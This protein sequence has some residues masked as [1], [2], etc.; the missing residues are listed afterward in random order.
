MSIAVYGDVIIDEYIYGTATRLSPE[1][2][3]PVVDYISSEVKMGG[4]GNVYK[5]ILSLTPRVTMNTHA[6][7]LPVK[8]RIFADGHYVTRVDVTPKKI[9]W[10]HTIT[11]A[12]VIVFSDYNKGSYNAL[13]KCDDDIIQRFLDAKTIVDPKIHLSKYSECWCLKPNKKEF[14]AYVKCSVNL[15]NLKSLMVSAYNELNI[16]HLIV[17]L[18]SDGVAHYS[19]E[20]GYTHFPA[21]KVDVS[22]VTGAG[23][24]FT[25]VLAYAIDE[26]KTMLQAIAIANK[27]AGIAVKHHGTYVITPE[28]LGS[29]KE[30]VVFTNGCFD[31]LHPGHIHILREAKKLGTHL[32]VAINSDESVKRLKGPTRPVNSISHRVDM[33]KSLEI[34]DEVI[35]FNEDTPEELIK[36]IAPDIIVK[37]GDYNPQDVVGFDVAKVVIIP[38]LG[39][40]STTNII[41]GMNNGTA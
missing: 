6:E 5:N 32:I 9:E 20:T 34:A 23:D 31:I 38:T 7:D 4:A 10:V 13:Y 2:P 21:D 37:G 14:E 8:K 41:K 35:V 11:D 1:A 36:N 29:I 40:Y 25:A 19:A 27:A 12:D 30:T 3:V 22:D 24:T 26:G 18:G 17:T 33:I 16:H 28:D 15:N 39:S